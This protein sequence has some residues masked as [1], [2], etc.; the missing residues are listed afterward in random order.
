[1]SSKTKE[2]FTNI[3]I[4]KLINPPTK[5]KMSIVI[6]GSTLTF[7]LEDDYLA[8]AFFNFG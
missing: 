2:A 4:D 7:V 6:D 3:L 5:P 8:K 1:M